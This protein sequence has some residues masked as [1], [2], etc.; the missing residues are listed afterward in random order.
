MIHRAHEDY[1]PKDHLREDHP[2]DEPSHE[3]LWFTQNPTQSPEKGR[4]PDIPGE[5]SV[6]FWLFN[7]KAQFPIA[8]L[9]TVCGNYTWEHLMSERH[10]LYHNQTVMLAF[11]PNIPDSSRTETKEVDREVNIMGCHCLHRKDYNVPCSC[12]QAMADRAKISARVF[13]A[14][15]IVVVSVLLG[16]IV[17]YIWH[18]GKQCVENPRNVDWRI[19]DHRPKVLDELCSRSIRAEEEQLRKEEELRNK[20]FET[21]LFTGI[22]GDVPRLKAEKAKHAARERTWWMRSYRAMQS[23]AERFPIGRR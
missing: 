10:R 13:F 18:I 9:T 4:I 3:T 6:N 7:S 16:F 20:G 2:L 22:G 21:N 15:V 19:P 17:H 8:N 11:S 23:L 5:Y 14:M 12:E 1:P